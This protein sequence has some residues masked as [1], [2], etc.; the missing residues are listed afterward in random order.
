MSSLDIQFL[1]LGT[2][3]TQDIVLY[4]GG[5]ERFTD[6]QI[7][8]LSR[9][10]IVVIVLVTYLISLMKLPGVF[11][12]G[13][14]CFSGFTSLVPLLAASLYWKR[15]TRAGAYAGVLTAAV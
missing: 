7:I 5:T 14:W 12:L 9:S 15:L 11:D 6:R 1:C 4:Y 2:M 8:W 10:F 3:F 13:I